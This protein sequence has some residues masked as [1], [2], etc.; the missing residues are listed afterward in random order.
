MMRLRMLPA[1]LLLLVAVLT[2][3]T[4]CSEKGSTSTPIQQPTESPASSAP[5]TAQ[6]EIFVE[7][8]MLDDSNVE[9]FITTNIPG[10]IEVVVDLALMA[11]LVLASQAPDGVDVWVIGTHSCNV[12]VCDGE[13]TVILDGSEL[14]TGEYAVEATL[15]PWWGLKDDVSRCCGINQDFGYSIDAAAAVTL[16]GSGESVEDVRRHNEGRRWVMSNFRMGQKWDPAFWVAKFGECKQLV[17]DY[18]NPA[19][20]KAYY[21]ASIDM[22]LMVNV[23]EGTIDTYRDGKWEHG[24]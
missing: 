16:T 20:I 24:P 23:L 2:L 5:V 6:Y 12:S 13:G 14:P 15:Y 11:D 7:P 22:T 10:E 9:V 21:F 18:Y 1:M 19:I 3:T 8:R 17:V 4:G